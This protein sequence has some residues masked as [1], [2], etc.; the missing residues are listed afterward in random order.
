M[1]NPP[2]GLC[3]GPHP[4]DTTVPS[5]IWNR[6]VRAQ[7]LPDYLCLTCIVRAFVAAK[8]SFTAELI[9]INIA[10]TAIEVRVDSRDARDA[11]LVSEENTELRAALAAARREERERCAKMFDG[12]TYG[13]YEHPSKAIRALQDEPE[14]SE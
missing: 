5:V 3:G 2:C 12:Y 1:I 13:V 9:G 7:G 4:F 11:V 6:I 14:R 10:T 8:E